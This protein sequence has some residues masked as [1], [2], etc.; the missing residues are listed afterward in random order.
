LVLFFKKE[1][2]FFLLLSAC[3]HHKAAVVARPPPPASH[4]YLLG[5][6]RDNPH[7]PRFA[8][9]GWSPFT[10]QDVVAIALREWRLWG[11]PVDDDPPETRPI[12]P[13]EDKPE[14]E[15]GLWQRVGE[16]WWIGDDAD[17][18]EVSWTGKH[19]ET[20]ALFDAHHDAYYAWSAAFISY[21]MRIAGAASGFPYSAAHST[22]INLAAVGAS[23]RL[24]AQR[25][26]DYAP[27]LG[28]LICTGRGRAKSMKFED[29]PTQSPFPS[30]CDIVV[31][32][33]PGMLTVI[34]G[35]VDDA[36]TEKHVPVTPA[37]M[38]AG[39]DGVV[40]DTRYPW[41]VVLR[42]KYDAPAV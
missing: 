13:P 3:A 18:P 28:D 14:R 8:N 39:P 31:G 21:V 27:A 33:R 42:V 12:P 20:G 22:Y 36:V 6:L 23:P 37:G 32:V 40:V 24:Q 15:P 25:V 19:D 1:L 2:L 4:R 7:V 9:E 17:A 34:G 35:N 11:Q 26:Q 29:L 41:F 38:L 16:Y 10:R 30:H 5:P